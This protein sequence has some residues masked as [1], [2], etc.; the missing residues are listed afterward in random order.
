MQ[1]GDLRFLNNRRLLHGR[2]GF[3][4][5]RAIE[6]RRHVMRLWLR[7]RDMTGSLPPALKLAWARIFDDSERPLHWLVD[8]YLQDGVWHGRGLRAECD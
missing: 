3:S 1:P 8:P 7:N 4:D 2:E 6:S 5:A